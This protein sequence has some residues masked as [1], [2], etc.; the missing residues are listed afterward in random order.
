RPRRGSRP[1][2]KLP[3]RRARQQPGQP[4]RQQLGRIP[5]P[6]TP[7]IPAPPRPPVRPGATG[8]WLGS[9]LVVALAVAAEAGHLVAGYAEWPEA[10][11]RGAYHVL[12]GA[13]LG[14]V[15][16]ALLLATR[17]AVRAWSRVAGT[18][19]A[20]S[21]PVLWLAGAPLDVSPYAVMAAA[22]AAAITATEVALVVLLLFLPDRFLPGGS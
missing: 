15:A 22:A 14:L 2:G 19:V 12:A 6:R 3:G 20:L 13:L 10:T 17:P 8:P 9:A 5:R 11:A 4:A 18:V 7:G 16:A 21:G 1:A